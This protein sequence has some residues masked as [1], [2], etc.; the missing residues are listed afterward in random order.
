MGNNNWRE[1]AWEEFLK[2]FWDN[3]PEGTDSILYTTKEL[4]SILKKYTKSGQG[5]IRIFHYGSEKILAVQ[6]R[7]VVKIP[8]SRSSWKIIKKQNSF[9]F[10]EP[11]EGGVFVPKNKLTD[12]M[13]LGVKDTMG[14]NSNPGETTLMAIANHTGIIE[15]FYNLEEQGVLFTGGRQKA[16]ITLT[17]NGETLNMSKAQIEIDGGF[18]WPNFVVIVEMKSSFKQS[19]FDINQAMIPYLKWNKILKHKTVK[20]L[21][22]LAETKT[23]YI[24]Y[25]AYDITDLSD[26]SGVKVD[27]GM[28]KK[29]IIKV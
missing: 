13:F 16:G 26:S 27:I 5:E 23:T 15:D 19:N 25:W 12:G 14:I 6:K 2:E 8:V 20:N 22:L 1:E 3:R 21:V 18:E 9:I 17:I 7:G 10:T 11:I 4:N 28:S 29:Y 24:E